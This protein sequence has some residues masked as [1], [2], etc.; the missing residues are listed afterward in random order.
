MFLW[1]CLPAQ[2][3]PFPLEHPCCHLSL[4]CRYLL[5]GTHDEGA[6]ATVPDAL[7]FPALT[8]W[9]CLPGCPTCGCGCACVC[10]YVCVAV[11]ILWLDIDVSDSVIAK[12]SRS[13]AAAQ[14]VAG[15]GVS[16]VSAPTTVV[17]DDPSQRQPRHP[18]PPTANAVGRAVVGEEVGGVDYTLFD[19]ADENET[20]GDHALAGTRQRDREPHAGGARLDVHVAVP[21][22]DPDMVVC[23]FDTVGGGVLS[24]GCECLVEAPSLHPADVMLPPPTPSY[25]AQ[26]RR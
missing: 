3:V 21:E 16:V 4:Y 1:C 5:C 6:A 23:T 17:G 2:A 10:V 12:V 25:V 13:A 14:G 7:P 24:M 11:R 8:P 18:M 9:H 19:T 26:P 20:G 22:D 15:G